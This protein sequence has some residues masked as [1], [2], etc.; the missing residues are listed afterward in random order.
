MLGETQPKPNNLLKSRASY[1]EDRNIAQVVTDMV[2]KS[3]CSLFP[4]YLRAK[5]ELGIVILFLTRIDS[6]AVAG[7]HVN[8][9]SQ[10]QLVSKKNQREVSALF[11][12]SFV[13]T[14]VDTLQ[15]LQSVCVMSTASRKIS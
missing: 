6:K 7:T 4:L 15:F 2:I 1:Q 14:L 3:L 11:K 12:T 5:K 9:G 13:F 10:V 8:R